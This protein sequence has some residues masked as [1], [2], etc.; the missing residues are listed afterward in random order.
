MS[1]HHIPET[2][3]EK[4]TRSTAFALEFMSRV[5]V[6]PSFESMWTRHLLGL[7]SLTH[8]TS[9]KAPADPAVAQQKNLQ[10]LL[11]VH[12]TTLQLLRHES[13]QGL[14]SPRVDHT[15]VPSHP[16]ATKIMGSPPFWNRTSWT[17]FTVLNYIHLFKKWF[18]TIECVYTT[19]WI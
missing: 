10:R 12:L 5:F 9:S 14:A 11:A 18:H 2:F 6:K 3:S 8:S 7:T 16:T 19:V 4:K 15:M 17:I 13:L 1:T